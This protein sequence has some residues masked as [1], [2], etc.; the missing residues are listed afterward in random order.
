MDKWLKWGSVEKKLHYKY[1]T[2][3]RKLCE[4]PQFR[5]LKKNSDLT[6]DG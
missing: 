2:F 3:C 6:D 1:I 5:S 4:Q